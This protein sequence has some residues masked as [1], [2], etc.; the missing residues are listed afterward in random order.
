MVSRFCYRTVACLFLFI[1]SPSANACF[2]QKSNDY[3]LSVIGFYNLENLFDTINDPLINDEEFLPRGKNMWNTDKYNKKLFNMATILAKLGAD[4]SPL[5]FTA[6]GVAEVENK[7][8]LIDLCAHPLLA[9]RK[10]EVIHYDSPDERGIDVALIYNPTYFKPVASRSVELPLIDPV[11]KRRN[12]TRDALHVCGTVDGDTIN[13]LVNHWPSR[14]GGEKNSEYGRIAAAEL[15]K[16]ITDSLLTADPMARVIIMGDLNDDPN[17]ISVLKVL[18]T[19]PSPKKL[20]TFELYNP[21]YAPWSKGNGTLAYRD[22]W[23][24]FDQM[25]LTKS[26]GSRSKGTWFLQKF[27]VFRDPI[28][29]NAEGDYK[30]YPFRTFAGGEFINGYSDHLPVYGVF[31]KKR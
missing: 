12:F 27:V 26:L 20:K 6:L 13:I 14:R 1:F 30:G 7:Q 3:K 25:I 4:V 9:A 5:G 21:S 24:L 15:N 17:N 8:V 10:L 16:A 11:D 2:A 18:N 31:L 29:F 22:S 23:N 19:K 28:L